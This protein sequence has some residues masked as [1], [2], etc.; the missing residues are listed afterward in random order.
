M[1][2]NEQKHLV[3]EMSVAIVAI[4]YKDIVIGHRRKVSLTGSRYGVQL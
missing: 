1:D 3:M 2:L 4:F